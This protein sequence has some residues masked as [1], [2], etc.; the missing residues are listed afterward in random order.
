MHDLNS[1]PEARWEHTARTYFLHVFHMAVPHKRSD[2]PR[3]TGSI[4]A[5]GGALP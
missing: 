2:D 4:A 3:P 1:F 5:C